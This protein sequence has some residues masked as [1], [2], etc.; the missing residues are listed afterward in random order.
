[1]KKHNIEIGSDEIVEIE[2]LFGPTIMCDI[3]LT[4]C[5][6]TCE[7]IIEREC[8]TTDKNE[9]DIIS[10]VEYIRIPAQESL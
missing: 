1:M 4:A 8:I 5:T 2:K 7:W 10:W 6:E 3:R 9:N